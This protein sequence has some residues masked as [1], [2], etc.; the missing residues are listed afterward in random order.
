MSTILSNDVISQ[1]AVRAEVEEYAQSNRVFRQAFRQIDSTDI[2][3]NTIEIPVLDEVR[4]A[5]V[6][7]EGTA[8]PS[9]GDAT[10][11]V[12][13]EHE[14]YG[15]E[16]EL[17]YESIEDALLDVIALHTEERAEDLADALDEAAYA[18]ISD[19]D[20]TNSVY[21]NLQDTP[22]GDDNGALTYPNVVN[23][24]TALE[25]EAYDPD[26]LIVSAES[27]GDLMTSDAFTRAS[28][29]GDEVVG[30]GAFGEVA[31]VPVFV[32][33]SGQLGAGEA[34]M[35]DSSKYGIESQ[36]EEMSSLEYDKEA[37]NKRVVQVRTR[38]GWKAIRPMAGV[39]IEG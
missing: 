33:N 29:L 5:G 38:M 15:V 20:S 3:S 10:Q 17:T 4:A 28:E 25:A 11:K 27:K 8:Y 2:D 36:R 19:Y 35:F 22:I 26:L 24:M 14:K 16:V 31:G 32:D 18:E 12:T 21:N 7:D 23:A 6:V 37:E 39:K 13:V 34:M 30:E 1:E 9:A